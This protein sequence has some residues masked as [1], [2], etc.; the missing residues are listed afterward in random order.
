MVRQQPDKIDGMAAVLGKPM[1]VQDLAPKDALWAVLLRSPYAHANILDIRTE[2]ALAIPGVACVLTYKDVKPIL[3]TIAAE[4]YPEG[5]PYDRILLGKKVRYVGDPVA[6]VAAKDKASADA[7]L[8]AIEVDYQVLEPILDFESALDNPVVIHPKEEVINLLPIDAEPDRNIAAGFPWTRGDADAE[9]AACDVVVEGTYYAP[10]QI[11]AMMETHRA[12]C[13]MDARGHLVITSSCQSPFHV[14]RIVSKLLGIE[15]HTVRV[16]KPKVGGAF[17]GKNSTFIEPFV[18]LVTQRTGKP[19]MMIFTREECFEATN[20][21]HQL[22][23]KITLGANREDGIIRAVKLEVL[24][25]TGAYGEHCIDVLAVS[26][27]NT[28]PIYGGAVALSYHGTAVYTNKVPAGAFRGF[29]APQVNFGLESIIDVLA[30]K[31]GV[32]PVEFRLRNII[33][34]GQT[35]PFLAGGGPDGDM[36]VSSSALDRCIL[37]GAEMIGWKKA[38]PR[39]ESGKGKIVGV[40]C[41]IA[42]HGSSIA[43]MDVVEAEVKLNYDGSFTVLAGASDLGTGAETILVQFAGEVM[44]TPIDRIKIVASDTETTPVDKGAY[45]SSTTYASGNAVVMAAKKLKAQIEEGA[46]LVMGC[47]NAVDFDGE[48]FLER[49]GPARLS[50]KDFLV[51]VNYYKYA[52]RYFR[53]DEIPQLSASARYGSPSA[54]PPY[55]A[56]FAEVEVDTKTGE[57]RLLKFASVA[58]CGTVVNPKLARI[59]LEGGLVQGIGYALYEDIRYSDK[60]SLQSNSFTSYHI[61][62]VKDIPFVM[63]TA[64]V[65]SYEPNGPFGAKSLGEVVVHTPPGAIANAVYNAVGVRINSLPITPEK[66][67]RGLREKEDRR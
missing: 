46:R 49:G 20:T 52:L 18:A 59:Q 40:G 64:F 3:H 27:K 10:A 21:R 48:M 22:R 61:P 37:R 8:A 25:N 50:L 1:Y 66:V 19:C 35:H 36:A 34:A 4:A 62:T 65:E 9:L 55:V 41:D 47:E 15:Q 11:H 14:Q 43:L 67:L 57:L 23:S 45:A 7:A 24:S 53:A 12:S 60:G 5:S 58:D 28:L 17:G 33:K 16:I 44:H 56:S 26:C 2:K 63:E 13:A 30:E 29:G 38:Y 32:D 51:K 6:V 54:P 31:L 42:M 39:R